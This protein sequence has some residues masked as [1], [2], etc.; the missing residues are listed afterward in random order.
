MSMTLDMSV[1]SF[2]NKLK[3]IIYN[4]EF[5]RG[6]RKICLKNFFSFGGKWSVQAARVFMAAF[7]SSNLAIP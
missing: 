1:L 6:K 2:E 7:G 3:T 5:W 4:I